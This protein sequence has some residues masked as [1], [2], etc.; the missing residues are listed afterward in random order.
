MIDSAMMKKNGS[1]KLAAHPES[2]QL[3]ERGKRIFVNVT[4]ARQIAVI[5]REKQSVTATWPMAKFQAHFPM[6]LDEAN[7]RLFAGCRKPARLVVFDTTTGKPVVDLGISGDTD[8]LFYDPVLKRLYVSC[9][10]GFIDVI[11]QRNA[12]SYQLRER[13][14][15][16][17]GA[18]TSFFSSDRNEFY[19]AVPTRG[20]QEAEIRVFKTQK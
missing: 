2:F 6:A 20:N 13:I 17:S 12:D 14:K 18:R 7:H 19:L 3:E 10:E 11:D 9:G 16:R 5:D 15:T 1:I 8:D 4:D